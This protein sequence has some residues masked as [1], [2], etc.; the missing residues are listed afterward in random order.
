MGTL[1]AES[2]RGGRGVS[3]EAFDR[4]AYKAY[5]GPA[6]KPLPMYRKK[7]EPPM[8]RYQETDFGGGGMG[9]DGGGGGVTPYSRNYYGEVG[10]P[11]VSYREKG[12]RGR[13]QNFI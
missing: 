4:R 6:K 9:G 8:P 7:R 11:R 10:H 1:G 3:A 13:I 12:K 2:R 5:S